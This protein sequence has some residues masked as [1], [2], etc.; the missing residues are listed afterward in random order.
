MVEDEWEHFIRYVRQREIPTTLDREGIESA[1]DVT[2]LD[3]SVLGLPKRIYY[4]LQQRG[5]MTV[6]E[7]VDV[8]SSGRKVRG[9]GPKYNRVITERLKEAGLS[10]LTIIQPLTSTI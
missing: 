10:G 6:G 3:I 5:V 8:I 9:I 4:T 2:A 1:P 7:L